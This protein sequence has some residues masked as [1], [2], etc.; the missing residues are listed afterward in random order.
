MAKSIIAQDGT[1]VNFDKLLAVYV[2]EDIDDNENVLG[3]DLI[4]VTGSTLYSQ[5]FILGSYED[6]KS[7]MKAHADL[8]HW[9][10][11]EAFSTFEVPGEDEGGDA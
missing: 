8:I 2:D 4:G 1:I 5:P 11:S 6:E 7:A 3:Y 10:Q 9:L